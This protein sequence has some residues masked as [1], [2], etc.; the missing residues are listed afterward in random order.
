MAR[1]GKVTVVGAGFYGSTTAQRLAQ[2]DLF[3]EV[4][5]TDVIEERACEA[6][7]NPLVSIGRR[8]AEVVAVDCP[9]TLPMKENAL[10]GPAGRTRKDP[11]DPGAEDA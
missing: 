6:H 1:N 10:L 4:V 9:D 8:Y 3:E 11:I 2:Y 5:L 7:G